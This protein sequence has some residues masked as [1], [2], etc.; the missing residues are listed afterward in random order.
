MNIC[1]FSKKKLYAK[2][3][4]K[5]KTKN[6]HKNTWIWNIKTNGECVKSDECM[7]RDWLS[8]NCALKN[9]ICEEDFLMTAFAQQWTPQGGAFVTIFG[10]AWL[11]LVVWT[12][13]SSLCNAHTLKS[14]LS[15]FRMNFGVTWTVSEFILSS[16]TARRQSFSLIFERLINSLERWLAIWNARFGRLKQGPSTLK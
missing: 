3:K 8:Q 14:T 15:N 6:E 13:L 9:N 4:I 11:W 12:V 10:L 16:S 7:I 2:I 5:M 1:K